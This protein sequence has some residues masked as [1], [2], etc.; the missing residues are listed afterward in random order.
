MTREMYEIEK[1]TYADG[2]TRYFPLIFGERQIN[3]FYEEIWMPTLRKAR[4]WVREQRA[5]KLREEEVS[6]EVVR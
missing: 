5:L 3:I 4:K 2:S 1:V 6:R